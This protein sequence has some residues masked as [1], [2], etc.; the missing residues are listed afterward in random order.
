M[1]LCY[2]KQGEKRLVVKPVHLNFNYWKR[3]GKA[4]R[5]VSFFYCMGSGLSFSVYL[6]LQQAKYH[7]EED[8]KQARPECCFPES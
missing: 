7:H 8:Y 5:D 3:T 1:Y 2:C 4:G 6:F